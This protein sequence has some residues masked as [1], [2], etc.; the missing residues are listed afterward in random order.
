[1]L[2]VIVIAAAVVASPAHAQLNYYGSI[3]GN[4]SDPSGG[5]VPGASVTVTNVDTGV[6]TT[7]FTKDAGFYELLDLIPGNYKITI[8]ARGFQNFVRE[9]VGLTGGQQV[10]IDASLS[11]G[12]RSE[13]ITVTGASPI[14]NTE[15]ATTILPTITAEQNVTLPNEGNSGQLVFPDVYNSL[16]FGFADLNNWASS[17]GGALTS[18]D[19]EIQ[20]GIR[21]S[22]QANPVGGT[23]GFI[24][25][26]VEDVSEIIV[27]TSNPTARYQSPA[28]IELVT[29]SGSNDWHGSLVYLYDQAALNA[30]NYFTHEENPFLLN[31]FWVSLGGPIRKNKTFFYASYQFSDYPA[32]STSLSSVPTNLMRQGNFSELLDPNFISQ[33]GLNS[34]ITITDPTTGQPFPG[35][36]IP[37]D[38][39]DSVAKNILGVIPPPNT[40][41]SAFINDLLVP[42]TSVIKE[43]NVDVRVDHYITSTQH[44]YGS[45][46]YFHVPAATNQAGLPGFG[47]NWFRDE[48]RVVSVHHTVTL[49]PAT[50]NEATFGFLRDHFPGGPGFFQSSSPAWNQELGIQ[51]IQP[52]LDQG[53]PLLTFQQ[54][55]LTTPLSYGQ[56]DLMEHLLQLRDELTWTHG[57][58]KVAAGADFRRDN[59]GS[60]IPG[61]GQTNA[62]TC[63]YGCIN[64]SGRWTGLDFADFLLALPF[65]STRNI[66]PPADM[67]PRNEWGLFVQDDM[68]WTPRISLSLGLRYDY[69]PI[70]TSEH[71]LEALFDP[72][73]QE[74]VVP[75]Q[76]SL[77]AIPQGLVVPVPIVTAAQ[78]GLPSSLLY[79]RKDDFEPRAGLAY[80]FASNTVFRA[81]AGVYRTPLVNTGRSLLTGPFS[82]TSN[83]PIAQPAAGQPPV[84]SL[85][86]P[87][88]VPGAAEPLLNFFAPETGIRPDLHYDFDAAIEHQIAGNA[89]TIEYVGKKSIVPYSHELNAVPPSL[90]PFDRSRLPFPDLGSVTGLSNGAHYNY[91]AL[92]LNARRRMAH[93]LFFDATYIYSSVIDDLSG[94]GGETAGSPENPFNR[95]RDRGQNNFMPPQRLTVNYMW[96]LPFGRGQRL[97]FSQD[98]GAARVINSVIHGWE[99]AG[100]YNFQTSPKLTPTGL[101]MN[102]QGQNYDA[103]NTNTF[104]G[105]PDRTD[106]P[107]AATSQEAAQGF[108]FNPNAFSDLVPAGN[109]GSSGNSVI[110]GT[111]QFFINESIFRNF[112]LPRQ[113]L[114]REGAKLRLGIL[115]FN[116]INHSNAPNPVTDLDSPIFGKRSN[117]KTGDTRT[118]ALQG[119]IDF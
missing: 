80:R 47:G 115:M 51:G 99:L 108:V 82:I 95:N 12:T 1:M 61:V 91:N 3:V 89:L 63:Q 93:G 4:V 54:T 40:Q 43:G 60:L 37:P 22:G 66:P 85:E 39:I 79:S 117:P 94:I 20:N 16:Y 113:L 98:E 59:Q 76:R 27:T 68:R 57:R 103:P 2:F 64:F 10:R 23:A 28:S 6:A 92:R 78:A 110:P 112:M 106:Q 24:H 14:I 114:H 118:V 97:G 8:T 25:P 56:A 70:V 109:Y 44:L 77:A 30:N 21:V 45:F 100:M 42:S 46:T 111:G 67:R 81:G 52:S 36:I 18:Q 19:D 75:S 58:H 62:S 7:V 74:L 34:T 17:V 9:N 11:V 41:G 88:S 71:G 84:L 83:F 102:A 35:N 49:T 13:S 101:Y 33:A 107:I 90:I 15:N 48:G 96:N 31:Q 55:S 65:S 116:A 104:S 38:R 69:F 29:K 119:R 26:G 72:L 87:Y 32:T 86:S 5:F 50:L 73:K 105:R 53:F